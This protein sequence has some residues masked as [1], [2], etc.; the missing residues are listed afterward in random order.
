MKR[1][2][3]VVA[4]W[5]MHGQRAWIEGFVHEF[6]RAQDKLGHCEIALCPPF[7]YLAQLQEH[8]RHTRVRLGA[9]NAHETERGAFTG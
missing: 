5:K 7:V 8:L 6:I 9:Q 4:N 3:L 2:P 1:Q